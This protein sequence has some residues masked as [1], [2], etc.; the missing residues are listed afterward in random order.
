MIIINYYFLS[1][2]INILNKGGLRM[3]NT[4]NNHLS[5]TTYY[6]LPKWVI[7]LFLENKITIKAFNIFALM[8]DRWRFS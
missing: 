6:Q 3:I 4:K 5:R 1:L 7:S 2:K 8:Y